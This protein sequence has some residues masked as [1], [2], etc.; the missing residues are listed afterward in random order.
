MDNGAGILEEHMKNLFTTFFT[1]K[2]RGTG[3]GLAIVKKIVDEHQGK[4]EMESKE[5]KGTTVR[6]YL[7]KKFS[8]HKPFTKRAS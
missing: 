2:L 8:N 6:V 3:L 5:G 1:T 4:I 7:P